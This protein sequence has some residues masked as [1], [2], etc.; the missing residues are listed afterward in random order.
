MRKLLLLHILLILYRIAALTAFV[1]L[2]TLIKALVLRLR[3][4]PYLDR[5]LAGRTLLGKR[6][7]HICHTSDLRRSLFKMGYRAHLRRAFC[8]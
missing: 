2:T 7:H 8:A 3:I 6:H 5:L 4:Y 1:T